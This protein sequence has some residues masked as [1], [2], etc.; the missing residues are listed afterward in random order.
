MTLVWTELLGSRRRGA[1]ELA[2]AL[3]R[4]IAEGRLAPGERLPAHR[5]L[6]RTLGIGI[7][8]VTRA[9]ALA[10]ERRLVSGEVGRGTFVRAQAPGEEPERSRLLTGPH[11]EVDLGLNLPLCTPVEDERAVARALEEL[12]PSGVARLLG[13]PWSAVEERQ[14]L[15]GARWL[16]RAGLT[17]VD[18]QQVLFSTGF[19]TALQAVLRALTRPG[20]TV[21]CEALTYP[22][23]KRIARSLDLHL[24]GVEVDRDGIV[25]AALERASRASGA[26]VVHLR[27]TLSPV[28][29]ATLPPARRKELARIARAR[30][31]TIVEEDEMFPL[32]EKPPLPL[33]AFAPERTVLIA[34]V[35]RATLVGLRLAYVLA[36]QARHQALEDAL[37][38]EVWMPSALLA[39]LVAHWDEDGA[40]DELITARR[41]ELDRRGDLAR[42]VLSEF[43]VACPR[44][45]TC[46]WLELPRGVRP[47]ELALL[48]RARG[49]ELFPAELFHPESGPPPPRAVRL[50]LCGPQRLEDLERGL[51]V[52]AQLAGQLP[53]RRRALA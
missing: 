10:A 5:E 34:D 39:E 45:S 48:A 14:R 21:L 31:L 35:T 8:T 43:A 51:R 19:H 16:A 12:G 33:A 7:G 50:S 23:L 41:A 2:D 30:E 22:G 17:D 11:A 6:A 27:P 46:A 15:A 26:R 24:L 36:P 4:A 20:D 53:S 9:Y 37:H 49:V 28:T 13:T 18:P 1:R 29:T 44:R 38:H 40:L 52:V 32:L 47:D 42:E 3:G 25:P